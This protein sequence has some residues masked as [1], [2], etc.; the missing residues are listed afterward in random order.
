MRFTGVSEIYLSHFSLVIVVS[1]QPNDTSDSID[2]VGFASHGELT[3]ESKSYKIQYIADIPYYI[4]DAEVGLGSE[5]DNI[6]GP[7]T[8]IPYMDTM[9]TN[10]I[11]QTIA[12]FTS[13]D[14]VW[15]AGFLM[16]VVFDCSSDNVQLAEDILK[17][18][19]KLGMGNVRFRRECAAAQH[20]PWGPYWLE[21][22][23]L[24]RVS[25]LYPDEIDAFVMSTA[26]YGRNH[27]E[28]RPLGVA[29]HG[30]FNPASL[31]VAVPSRMYYKRS[32]TLPFAGLRIAVKDNTD[33]QGVRTGASSRSY[34]RLYGPSKETAPT[35][36]R[37]LEL[38]AVVVGKTKSTQFADTEWATADWIDF[39]APFSPR[40]DGYQSP[41]G[42]SAGSGAA[43]AALDWLDF[44]TGTDGCGCRRR[45]VLN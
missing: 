22:Q 30:E 9:T 45:L 19:R 13:E 18:L 20:L 8:V 37:L 31:S 41:S 12:T 1:P 11:E 10:Y 26:P 36:R 43:I 44:A 27:L 3:F 16:T 23:K 2:F 5:N 24:C 35:V 40:A 28:Y 38:G 14:A 21:D 25:R 39:H 42:S 15:S 17:L 29:V 33:L 7:C 34:T 4:S 6:T 32:A